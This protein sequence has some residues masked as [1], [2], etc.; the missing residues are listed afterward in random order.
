MDPFYESDGDDNG[1]D[2]AF[3]AEIRRQILLLTADDDKDFNKNNDSGSTR[4]TTH[5]TNYGYAIAQPSGSYF[6]WPGNENTDTIP[7]R[8]LNLWRTGNGT[9]VFIP[10]VV[11]PRRRHNKPRRKKIDK[12]RTYQPVA[13]KN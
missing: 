1:G 7:P 8:V 2:D 10:Q 9:G 5:T 13:H 12:G 4:V 3:Y 6:F 11:K